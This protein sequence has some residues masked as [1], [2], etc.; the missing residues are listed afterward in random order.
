MNFISILEVD[1]QDCWFQ[2]GGAILHVVNSTVQV[3]SKDFGGHITS[4][5]LWSPRSLDLSSE[6]FEAEHAQK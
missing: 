6:V 5:N 3:L 1:K 4:G 2:Q